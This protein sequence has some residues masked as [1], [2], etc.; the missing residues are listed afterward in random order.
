MLVSKIVEHAN[1][2]GL[3][4]ALEESTINEKTG[5]VYRSA[6]EYM[7][8]MV[9]RIEPSRLLASRTIENIFSREDSVS[10][11]QGFGLLNEKI[12]SNIYMDSIFPVLFGYIY[13]IYA[14]RAA[15]LYKGQSLGAYSEERR[16]SY[17][18]ELLDIKKII[19]LKKSK[20]IINTGAAAA[21]RKQKKQLYD[22]AYS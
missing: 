15:L 19:D 22:P 14:K 1:A 9:D 6:E 11:S 8:D 20:G 3:E 10:G 5:E 13:D 12:T 4:A 21:S 16:I 18:T 17:T 2:H 7:S